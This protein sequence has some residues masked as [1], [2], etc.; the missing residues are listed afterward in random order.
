MEV[1]IEVLLAEFEKPIRGMARKLAKQDE[2][3]FED[4]CQ[5]GRLTLLNVNQASVRSNRSSMI[6]KAVKCRMIDFLRSFNPARYVSLDSFI[7]EGWQLSGVVTAE[8]YL[9]PP[10]VTHRASDEFAEAPKTIERE[11]PE[12]VDG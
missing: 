3:L 11:I 1:T 9:R 4:L 2:D 5:I 6:R 12:E 7:E 8:M 10:K